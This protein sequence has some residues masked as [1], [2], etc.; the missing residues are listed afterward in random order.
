MPTPTLSRDRQQRSLAALAAGDV[1]AAATT[2]GV[3]KARV[4]EIRKLDAEFSAEWETAQRIWSDKLEEEARRRAVEGVREPLV[5]DGK[6]IRD[7]DGQPIVIRRYSDELLLAFLRTHRP[8]KFVDY[9]VVKITIYPRWLQYLLAIFVVSFSV[10]IVG[11]LILQ[12]IQDPATP[13]LSLPRK[14]SR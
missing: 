6:I 7:D 13:K 11:D 5:S 10:W 8:E 4:D 1:S 12:A 14:F 3:S 9:R 2:A